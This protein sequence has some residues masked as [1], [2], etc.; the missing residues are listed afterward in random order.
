MFSEYI[1]ALVDGAKKGLKIDTPENAVN[2]VSDLI[3]KNKEAA[4]PAPESGVSTIFL[5]AKTW[6]DSLSQ[7]QKYALYAAAGLVVVLIVMK[8]AK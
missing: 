8:V 5:P 3:K 6:H 2:A 1:D 4:A 7:N